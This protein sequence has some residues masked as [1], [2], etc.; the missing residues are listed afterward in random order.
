M[1]GAI[2]WQGYK[3]YTDFVYN[4][5]MDFKKR[6]MPE[7][8]RNALYNSIH[9][10]PSFLVPKF[11]LGLIYYNE[12]RI[13]EAIHY[14]NEIIDRI[15]FYGE[16]HLL[17]GDI[18]YRRN[19]YYYSIEHYNKTLNLAFLKKDILLHFVHFSFYFVS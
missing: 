10:D 9:Y 5:A 18:Y 13:N 15:P 12:G 7:E 19:L 11:E 3:I 2:V 6:D 4:N 1:V 16:L 8:T 14:L 17:L